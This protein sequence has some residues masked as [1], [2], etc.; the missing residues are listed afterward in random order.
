M[1]KLVIWPLKSQ[2][3]LEGI[4]KYIAAD[5]YQNAEKVKVDIL[6]STRKIEQNPEM[7]PL[8]KYKKNNDGSFR[9][10]EIHH[11]RIAYRIT[12]DEIIITR[13]RHTSMVPKLY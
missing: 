1:V 9:A 5:S 6:S 12:K 3:Q 13:I 11:Y 4:I 10:Y 8:D 7:Y 2:H